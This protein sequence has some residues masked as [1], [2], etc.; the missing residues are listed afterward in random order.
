[1]LKH[2]KQIR[3]IGDV[4]NRHLDYLRLTQNSIPSIQIG[5]MGV[6]FPGVDFTNTPEHRFF[7]GNHDNP[8]KCREHPNYM[9]DFGYQKDLDLFWV[10]GADSIDVAWRTEGVTWWPDEQLSYDDWIKVI[11]LYEQ[12]KPSIVLSHDCPQIITDVLYHYP[13]HTITRNGLQSMFEIHKPEL[14]IYGHHHRSSEIVVEG[15][16]FICLN[17]L[18][19]IDI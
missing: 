12:T 7:R 19:F 2:L 6:G 3:I 8:K 17:E 10:S 9:G 11:D 1:M 15:T 13:G 14:W 5:D 4:H 18:E 16:K